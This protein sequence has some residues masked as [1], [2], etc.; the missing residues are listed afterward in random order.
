M[1]ADVQNGWQFDL[2]LLHLQ[3]NRLGQ[4][5]LST[6]F[7]SASLTAVSFDAQSLRRRAQDPPPR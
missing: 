1:R 4:T 3:P 7:S 6:N 5:S 2:Y